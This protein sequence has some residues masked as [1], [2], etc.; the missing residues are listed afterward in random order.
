MHLL[1]VATTDGVS[2]LWI[3]SMQSG[4]AQPLMGTE[5][6]QYPFFA[7]DGTAV[8]FFADARLKRLTLGGGV[9]E[10]L[11][12]LTSP[13]P[14]G[15]S[16]STDGTILYVPAPGAQGIFRIKAM[17]GSV[18]QQVTELAAGDA[19][20]FP[21]MLPDGQHYVYFVRSTPERMGIYRGSLAGEPAQRLF[22]ADTGAVFASPDRLLFGRQGK[23]FAQRL[24]RRTWQLSGEADVVSSQLAVNPGLFV[25]PLAASAHGVIAY[26]A[27]TSPGIAHLMRFDRQGRDLGLAGDLEAP[28]APAWS[29][30]GTRLVLS[31]TVNENVDI[32]T[33]EPRRGLSTRQTAGPESDILPVWSP[34]GTKIVFASNRTR[35]FNVYV[36]SFS[37]ATA[38]AQALWPSP[39]IMAPSDWSPDGKLIL[40]FTAGATQQPPAEGTAAPTSLWVMSVMVITRRSR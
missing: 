5:G 25:P 24:D 16:W 13:F 23:L 35:T 3:R 4:I 21:Q 20:L 34:D 31:R 26:R 28:A 37:S 6:A 17:P 10:T 1:F 9:V 19:H 7:P 40:G 22:F 32:W 11:V 14:R 15:G 30:D 36:L 12:G 2:R 8:G 29:H 39:T 18:P 27:E 38:E 33:Y